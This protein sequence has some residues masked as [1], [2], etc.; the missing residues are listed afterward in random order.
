MPGRYYI[1]AYTNFMRNF[2]DA[3]HYLQEVTV[4]G[5]DPARRTTIDTIN[6]DIQLFPEGGHLL[7][8]IRNTIGIK[9]LVNGKGIVFSGN[10]ANGKGEPIATFK[11]QHLGMAECQFIYE[12]GKTYTANIS[13]NDTLIRIKVPKALK[14]GLSLQVDNSDK[15]YLEVAIKTN[16]TTFYNQI[17]SN[18]TLLYHQ[19]RQIFA[20]ISIDRLDSLT[21]S[22]KTNKGIFFNGVNTVTLFEDD[23]PI[24]ERRFFIENEPKLT[25]ITIEKTG[26]ENDS[27]KYKILV[28][29]RNRPLN[30]DT[31]SKFGSL[32]RKTKHS[33][34][35]LIDSFL[36]RPHRRSRLLS[37]SR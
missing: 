33:D 17:Y 1:Q 29:N 27:L 32:G 7:E 2:G 5:E 25:D 28:R 13:I 30:F 34:R 6:Y 8:G 35:F 20:L 26:L 14:K 18:Y 24:A 36:K 11:D 31:S 9:A 21:S 3:Y 16:E 12:I 15:T 22:I 37:R 4:V 19:D 23:R 10:I